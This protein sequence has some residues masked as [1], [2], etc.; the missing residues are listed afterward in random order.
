MRRR[1]PDERSDPVPENRRQAP[2]ARRSTH[3]RSRGKISGRWLG[4]ERSRDRSHDDVFRAAA[5]IDL[6]HA[7]AV[8][9]AFKQFVQHFEIARPVVIGFDTEAGL[10]PTALPSSGHH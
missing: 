2:Q 10:M 6:R 3:S 9:R 5:L 8:I 7:K 1:I 4:W